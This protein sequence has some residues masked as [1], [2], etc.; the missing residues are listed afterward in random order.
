MPTYKSYCRSLG[1]TSFRRNELNKEIESQ[2]EL[3]NEFWGLSENIGKSWVGNR[4]TQTDYYNFMLSKGFVAGDAPN[5]DKDAREKTSGLV[6][7]GLVTEDRR[8]TPIGN[9]LLAIVANKKFVSDNILG[10]SEDSFVY[11]KQL[12]KTSFKV[13][14]DFVRPFLVIAN[15]LCEYETL[16]YEEFWLLPLIINSERREFIFNS[17]KNLRNGLKQADDIIWK[18]MSSMENYQEAQSMLLSNPVSEELITEIGMNRDG[19]RHD[20]PYYKLYNAL[21]NVR[22]SN[23]NENA[24]SLYDAIDSISEGCKPYWKK[25]LFNEQRL[26]RKKIQQSGLAYVNLNLRLFIGDDSEFKKE[27]FR[28]LHLIKAKNLLDNYADL[29]K[30]ILKT[31]NAI[32]FQ[33]NTVKLDIIPRCFFTLISAQLQDLMFVQSE[34]LHENIPLESI[35]EIFNVKQEEIVSNARKLYGIEA[36]NLYGVQSFVDKRR[37][38]RLNQLIDK[39]FTDEILVD[40]MTKFENRADSDIQSIVT[41][42]AD[43]P[44]IFEYVL[45]IVWYKISGR[46]GKVL[47]YMNLSLDADLLPITHAAGGHEDITYKYEAT[48]DYPKHTLLIEATLANGTNQRRMEMEPVSRHLGDYLISHSEE[49][50]CV[51]ATTFLHVNVVADFRSRKNTYYYS[52]SDESKYVDGMKIIPCNTAELKTIIQ[53]G[54]TYAQLYKIFEAAYQANTIPNL[55]Y[56]Q[57]IINK[58]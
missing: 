40:L 43:I 1:T 19:A 55:W 21:L 47:E 11:L 14:Q 4:E 46:Q 6:D 30:R 34:N 48:P 17:I 54:I 50:Y 24:L 18:I 58:L 10:I 9:A 7:L 26:T 35:S 32:I 56:Q 36:N 39:K 25:L 8:V 5:K 22:T 2:L 31:T 28:Y 38:E 51:F 23:T 27:F 12:I 41:N 20:K 53:R 29:N 49:A 16:S 37:Y 45:A 13:N 52:V 15:A 44:T 42:N 3:L 33:D 57:E